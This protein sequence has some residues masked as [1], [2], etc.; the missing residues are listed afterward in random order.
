MDDG[1][2]FK[3]ECFTI[4]GLCMKIHRTLGKGFR[5]AVYKDALEIELQKAN[6]M[7]ERE[8]K[9]K[10][11]YEGAVL[12]HSFDADFLIYKSI[13]VE[14]KAASMLHADAFRQTLNYLKSAHIQLAVLIN[15]GTDKL[16]FQRI[17]CTS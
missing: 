1:L 5:E 6:I 10:I 8:K 3:E 17:I 16:Q 4:V 12:R 15:F 9:F 7:Y 2:I 14:I 11:E 13:I